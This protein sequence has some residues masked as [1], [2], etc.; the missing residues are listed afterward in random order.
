MQIQMSQA[1]ERL[2]GA[3][4]L[5]EQAAKRPGVDFERR[6]TIDLFQEAKRQVLEALAAIE[7][8]LKAE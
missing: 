8:Q 7:E 1:F 6:K 3:V 5:A 2:H 4:N